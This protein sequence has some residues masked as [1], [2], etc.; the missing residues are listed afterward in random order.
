[1]FNFTIGGNN[2]FALFHEPN[3]VSGRYQLH[4]GNA[5]EGN[6]DIDTGS[7]QLKDIWRHY[8]VVAEHGASPQL[9]IDGIK[10]GTWTGT[11]N[12]DSLS[13]IED[14]AVGAD[15]DT[16]N[17]T[18]N[19]FF[20]GSM[21]DFR[22]Y[23][24]A[25]TEKEVES[26]YNAPTAGIGRTIIEGDRLTTGQ[27]R[28]NNW[29]P[30]FGSEFNLD[31]GTFKLGGRD[32]PNLEFD[33]TDLIVSGAISASRGQ[34][35]AFNITG[36]D[37]FIGAKTTDGFA[38]NNADITVGASGIH[39]KNFFVNSSDG[40]AGFSGTLT[41]NASD[42]PN[43][44]ISGSA[45]FPDGTVS[46]SGQLGGIFAT[47]TSVT[48][49]LTTFGTATSASLATGVS[50]S[51]NL[52]NTFL[53]I[54]VSGSLALNSTLLS[55]GVSGSLALNSTLLSAGV[56]GSL[57]FQA[58][59]SNATNAT[60]LD[61]SSSIATTNNAISTQAT[62]GVNNAATAQTQANAGVANAAT[63]QTQANAG[64]ANALTAQTKAN[65]A[66]NN[67]TGAATSASAALTAAN[68]A[69]TTGDAAVVTG[70]AAV[71][72]A[73]AAQ[74]DAT[75]AIVSASAVDTGFNIDFRSFVSSSGTTPSPY[76]PLEAD[77]ISTGITNVDGGGIWRVN[78]DSSETKKALFTKFDA[79]LTGNTYSD[80]NAPIVGGLG[81]RRDPTNT[82][83]NRWDS[84]LRHIEGL[85]RK[86]AP[87]F[88]VVFRVPDGSD[89]GFATGDTHEM[90]G[91]FENNTGHTHADMGYGLYLSG[92]EHQ[93]LYPII[94]IFFTPFLY[95]YEVIFLK[96][97][98]IDLNNPILFFL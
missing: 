69:Q 1:M 23:A 55:A 16:N 34:I 38:T 32:L 40:T 28:S 33:G 71:L 48:G 50:G 83:D 94:T 72:S 49:S 3:N 57:A 59:A 24:K 7:I 21:A 77:F 35:A 44:I 58:S 66:F 90:I 84:S 85:A 65:L 26:L 51:I 36:E 14:L 9:W 19:D 27:I 87:S 76:N 2:E 20:S 56:S 47:A 18:H 45:Q 12:N 97:F 74:A 89:T 78:G 39:T 67:N 25:L 30:S 81:F 42:L 88:E 64:V 53:D 61:A 4:T 54:G 37:L 68:N 29:G 52:A 60:L 13:S 96:C 82:H 63:A 91:W 70:D 31:D 15:H 46:G 5:A 98:L 8:T 75:A 11:V 17:D 86:N 95:S 92:I 80:S 41:I 93:V 43:G 10:R 22:L 6:L 73:D 79:A 62:L